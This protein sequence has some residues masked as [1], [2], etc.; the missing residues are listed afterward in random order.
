V[1]FEW[2]T[3]GF[4]WE[5]GKPQSDRELEVRTGMGGGFVKVKVLPKPII[6]VHGWWAGAKGW[7]PAKQIIPDTIPPELKGRVFAVGDG[8]GAGRMDTDP[9]T[10]NSI[11]QNATEEALYIKSIRE[12]LDAAHVDLVVHSMGG[13]ISRYYIQK[14]MPRRRTRR[15]WSRIW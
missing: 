15:R 4:A 12:R 3:S 10:G 2:D 14:L 11:A 7:D 5:K 13:L 1:V 8:Q 9:Q 6:A